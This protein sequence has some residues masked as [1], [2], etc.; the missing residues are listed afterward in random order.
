VREGRE[1]RKKS[2]APVFVRKQRSGVPFWS[3]KKRPFLTYTVKTHGAAA[4]PC[5]EK[6]TGEVSTSPGLVRPSP[7]LVA[8]RRRRGATSPVI[9]ILSHP[10]ASLRRRGGVFFSKKRRRIDGL[11]VNES[12]FI[13]ENP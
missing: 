5:G 11:C 1:T 4:P 2:T 13:A 9:H 12:K 8:P 3:V 6:S 10:S 7:G